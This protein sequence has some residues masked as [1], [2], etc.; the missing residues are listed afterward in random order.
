[1]E[2]FFEK[3][4]KYTVASGFDRNTIGLSDEQRQLVNNTVTRH[5]PT[6]KVAK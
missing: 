1:V 3:T 4:T 6:L 2:T 5:K